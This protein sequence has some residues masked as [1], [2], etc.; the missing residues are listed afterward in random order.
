MVLETRVLEKSLGD[1]SKKVEL[2]EKNSIIVQRRGIRAKKKLFKGDKITEQ[3]LVYLRPCPRTALNPYEKSK[4]IGKTLTRDIL[5]GEII[6]CE[7]T[8]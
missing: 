4:I 2:N 5:K 6:T 1:G 8:K 7:K 3:M